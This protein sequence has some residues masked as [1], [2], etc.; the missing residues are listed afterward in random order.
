MANAKNSGVVL[1]LNGNEAK[2]VAGLIYHHVDL[3]KSDEA[4]EIYYT[5][6]GVGVDAGSESPLGSQYNGKTINE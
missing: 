3:A 6:E 2:F 5:L 1:E 4:A